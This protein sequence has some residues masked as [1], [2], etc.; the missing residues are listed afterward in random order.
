MRTNALG[1]SLD[2]E[3]FKV[4]TKAGLENSGRDKDGVGSKAW[5]EWL[6][7]RLGDGMDPRIDEVEV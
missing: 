1:G 7:I 4:E 5:A 6:G 2:R 3:V